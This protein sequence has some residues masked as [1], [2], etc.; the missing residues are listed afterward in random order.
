MFLYWSIAQIQSTKADF[1]IGL[2]IYGSN[3]VVY[4]ELFF[5]KLL[6]S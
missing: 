2:R 5:E 3:F 4:N 1:K 6:F